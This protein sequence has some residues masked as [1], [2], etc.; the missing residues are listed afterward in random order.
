MYIDTIREIQALE[1]QLEQEKMRCRQQA[2][3]RLLEN[4]LDNLNRFAPQKAGLLAPR[5]AVAEDGRTGTVSLRL[6][7][8]EQTEKLTELLTQFDCAYEYSDPTE[9][10]VPEVP[11]KLKNNRFTRSMNCITEQ[12]SLPAYNGVDPNPIMAPFFIL[13]FGMMMA[14]M[15]YGLLMILGSALI[16]V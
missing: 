1:E 9:E 15:A 11:V 12:Y 5:P 6:G 4:A 13:F 10:D 14:D 3:L 8:R 7:S 2:N 16:L